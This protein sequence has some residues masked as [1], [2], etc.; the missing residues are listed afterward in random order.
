MRSV[1]P[2]V[3]PSWNLWLWNKRK[4]ALSAGWATNDFPGFVTEVWGHNSQ[5]TSTAN[6]FKSTH[7]LR[8]PN[9]SHPTRGLST[10]KVTKLL[11]DT[12]KYIK[13]KKPWRKVTS[14][15]GYMTNKMTFPETGAGLEVEQINHIIWNVLVQCW[16]LLPPSGWNIHY[17]SD[18][19][20]HAFE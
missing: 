12:K 5:R 18:K 20:P 4:A 16:S 7:G 13:K 8:V 2:G 9:N 1:P 14:S 10:V 6:T 3:S 17:I 19:T 15:S 11:P